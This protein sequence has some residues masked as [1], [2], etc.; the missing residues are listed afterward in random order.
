MRRLAIFCAGVTLG[1]LPM[2]WLFI[3]APGQFLFGV[4]QF[5]Q[6]NIE[7]RQA[8]GSPQNMELLSKLRYL[9][10]EIIVPNFAAC[11][12][13]LVPLAIF[14]WQ[15]RG[16]RRPFPTELGF[17]LALLPFL[18][19]GALAPS[20]T[21][22]QYFCTFVP[23]LLLIGIFCGSRLEFTARIVQPSVI[24]ALLGLVGS[25]FLVVMVY[26][27]WTNSLPR[28]SGRRS[29]ATRKRSRCGNI[30]AGRC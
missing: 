28:R 17:L 22:E 26:R 11:A 3:E 25:A 2:L 12:T 5:S 13:A 10:K 15:R 9:F 8:G 20:P 29:S 1:T 23:F 7:Y 24:A 4:L 19:I 14:V 30:R 18:L 27:N 6:A 16:T 21:F